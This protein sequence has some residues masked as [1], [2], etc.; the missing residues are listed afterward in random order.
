M[1][2]TVLI[3][4][5]ALSA[6]GFGAA[7]AGATGPIHT[8]E[9]FSGTVGPF[10]CAEFAY[11]EEFSGVDKVTIFGDPENPDRVLVEE[12]LYVKHIRLDTGYFVDETDHLHFEFN[13]ADA[14]F[15][16]VG[17]F[18]HLRDPSGKLIVTQAALVIF[19]TDTGEIVKITPS[20]NPD[21][22]AVVCP[23]LGGTPLT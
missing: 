14:T 12:Q 8:Q 5:F 19:N 3:F 21:P 9:T 20:L 7:S 22:F 17:V 16:Q 18:W 4:I 13:A 15:K 6:L 1:R 2:R 23:A 10:P 11:V